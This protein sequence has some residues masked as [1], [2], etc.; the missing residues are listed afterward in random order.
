MRYIL[1]WMT[2][3][4]VVGCSRAPH[5]K[6]KNLDEAAVRLSQ[7]SGKPTGPY[8]ATADEAGPNPDARV[9]SV[10]AAKAPHILQTMRQELGPGLVAFV[11]HIDVLA[12]PRAD[13]AEVVVA[14]GADQF[15][16][17]RV[18]KSDAA[19]YDKDTEDL[20]T[21]LKS[22]DEKYGID[23]F[24]AELDTIEFKLRTLPKDL[25]AFCKDLYEFCPDI[26]EQGAGDLQT[27]EKEI[28]RAQSV[29]LWWD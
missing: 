8:T 16:I 15:D 22:Y 21:R 29:Y 13:G 4:T 7:L 5:P 10:R 11:G 2:L 18:A 6:A 20:I 9:V 17:L 1:V 12:D 28:S 19:N 23:I 24:H 3:A 14:K 26:V 25:R 27:L